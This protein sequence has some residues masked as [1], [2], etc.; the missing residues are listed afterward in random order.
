MGH[1]SDD[2][3]QS[4]MRGLQDLKAWILGVTGVGQKRGENFRNGA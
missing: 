4:T 2:W 1:E 3:V